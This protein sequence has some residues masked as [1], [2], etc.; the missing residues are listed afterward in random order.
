MGLAHQRTLIV[1][2]QILHQVL[3]LLHRISAR[4][5]NRLQ[6]LQFKCQ[7]PQ[8]HKQPRLM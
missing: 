1:A 4:Y 5:P 8:L 2:A 7:Q 3:N 6:R